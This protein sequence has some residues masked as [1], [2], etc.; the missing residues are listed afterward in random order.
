[1]SSPI[2]LMA[3]AAA[4]VFYQVPLYRR[5]ANRS[6]VDLTVLFASSGGARAYDAG[7]G[8]PVT[9]DMPLLC[10][11]RHEFLR[12]AATNDVRGGFLALRDWD[13]IGRILRRDV[14]V[15]WVHSYSYLTTWLAIAAAQLKGVPVLL[16]EEQTLLRRRPWP[17][18]WV[19]AV[20]LRALFRRIHALSIGSANRAYFRHYGVPEERIFFVPYAADAET[21]QCEPTAMEARRAEI[22]A[23]F[24]IAPDDGPVLLVVGK[25]VARKGVETALGAFRRVRERHRC[26]LLVVGD[27]PLRQDLAAQAERQLISGD[28]HFACF[29]NRSEIARAY[30]AADVFLI[31]SRIEPWGLVVNEAMNFGLPV[32]ATEAVGSA[33]DLVRPG[34]NGFVVPVADEEAM[35]DALSVMVEDEEMR[36]RYGARSRELVAEWSFDRACA[37]VVEA[38]LFA[39]RQVTP[40]RSFEKGSERPVER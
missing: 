12:R 22:R 23:S 18:R 36:A 13:V 20:V 28:V 16:R 15:L 10:G 38:C 19:R 5:L 11:Y 34:E 14:D 32:V 40:A 2:R 7:F 37:G 26:A 24:G 9:W 25:L 21:L 8:R 29:L 6:D 27:G 31:P 3:L 17:K 4:P 1:M 33:Q 35:A 39:T 30:A